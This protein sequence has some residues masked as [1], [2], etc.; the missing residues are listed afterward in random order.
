MDLK[1]LLAGLDAMALQ[2]EEPYRNAL[3]VIASALKQA[4]MPNP[5]NDAQAV[6]VEFFEGKHPGINSLDLLRD[7]SKA[8]A[9]QWQA[10]NQRSDS[11][12]DFVKPTPDAYVYASERHASPN[13]KLPKIEK[14]LAK[15]V[16]DK[17]V[18]LH[19]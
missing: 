14:L 16:A 9:E 5:N 2:A 18:L 12:L 13:P 8:R 6:M 4:Q 1:S 15:F 7:T 10:R 11:N 19:K 17:T 3:Q